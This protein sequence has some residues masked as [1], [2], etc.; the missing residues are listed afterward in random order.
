MPL[1]GVSAVRCAEG[2]HQ[3]VAV[4]APRTAGLHRERCRGCGAHSVWMS[5]ADF[6]SYGDD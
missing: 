3:W 4:D 1:V 6:L 5:A 2:R